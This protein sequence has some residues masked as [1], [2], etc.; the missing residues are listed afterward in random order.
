M[1]HMPSNAKFSGVYTQLGYSQCE[2]NSHQRITIFFLIKS[3][4]NVD[5]SQHILFMVICRWTYGKGP[6]R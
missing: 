1:V 5:Y 4:S 6:L 3:I 2:I